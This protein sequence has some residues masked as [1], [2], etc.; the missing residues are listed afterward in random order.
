MRLRGAT[1]LPIRGLGHLIVALFLPYPPNVLEDE[2]CELLLYGVLGSS[3]SCVEPET[4]SHTP[5]VSIT[6]TTKRRGNI[7]QRQLP[8]SDCSMFSYKGP[9]IGP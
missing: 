2:S 7:T 8:F 9:P 3:L 4:K 5:A 1:V 6:V